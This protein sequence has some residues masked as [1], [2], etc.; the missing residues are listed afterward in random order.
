MFAE[1]NKDALALLP[2]SLNTLGESRTQPPLHRPEGNSY[3]QIIWVRGG[4]GIFRFP[5]ETHTLG[6]GMGVVMRRGVPHRYEGEQFHTAWLTFRGGDGLLD[7][8]GVG[9]CY[10]FR[11][12]SFLEEATEELDRFIAKNSTPLSRASATYSYLTELF[13]AIRRPSEPTEERIRM[14]LENRYGDSLSLE[15]IAA[16]AEM[17]KYALCRYFRRVRGHGVMEELKLIRIAKAKRFLR[18]TADPIEKIGQMC[19]FESPSYFSK[20]F[21]EVTGCSPAEYRRSHD[22]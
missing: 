10:V 20:R 2:F 8:C 18:Y 14:F 4:E 7:Y 6:V 22:R 16:Y 15:D 1:I 11:V 5:N 12:P 19:G 21:R 3:H 9:D 17:D 13:T